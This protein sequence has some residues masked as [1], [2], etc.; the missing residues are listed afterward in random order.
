MEIRQNISDDYLLEPC[1]NEIK[2][3]NKTAFVIMTQIRYLHFAREISWKYYEGSPPF[4]NE[5]VQKQCLFL[6]FRFVVDIAKSLQWTGVL[7]PDLISQGNLGLFQTWLSYKPSVPLAFGD[8]FRSYTRKLFT[9][10]R[11]VA[12][13]GIRKSM[14]IG[15]HKQMPLIMGKVARNIAARIRK[16]NDEMVLEGIR[17]PRLEQIARRSRLTMRIVSV[18]KK[19][20]DFVSLDDPEILIDESQLESAPGCYEILEDEETLSF[21]LTCIDRLEERQK[22]IL[23]LHYGL[24]GD[25]P[26]T[27]EE[28]SCAI[29]R[30]P[31]IVKKILNE[32]LKRLRKMID[33]P[34]SNV[35]PKNALPS[36]DLFFVFDDEDED[37]LCLL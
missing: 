29:G 33:L 8:D 27:I 7:L 23:D 2:N 31:A 12:R 10:F 11:S 35:S 25:I 26:R 3:T 14:S 24:T 9:H 13:N 32:S 16:A 17:S 19:R 21:M 37:V 22:V 5:D 28:I 1:F 6:S 34:P 15:I 4:L 36:D 20:L 18:C 30:S